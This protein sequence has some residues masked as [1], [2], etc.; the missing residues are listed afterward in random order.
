MTYIQVNNLNFT[1]DNATYKVFDN[2]SFAF[3]TNYKL[4]LIGRNGKGKTTFLKLLNNELDD[5]GAIINKPIT[6]YFP[7]NIIDET[8]DV[9]SLIYTLEPDVEYWKFLK[10]FHLLELEDNLLER[11]Y[12]TLSGGEKTKVQL[13]LLFSFDTHYLLIDE[14]T[15]H[16][17]L[18]GRYK[19]AEYLKKKDG[20]LL[21]SH[22]RSFLDETIDHVLSFDKNKIEL[23]SGNFSSWFKDRENIENLEKMRNTKL[24]KDI[25]KLESSVRKNVNWS[26]AVEKSKI[27]AGDKGYVGHMAAKAMKRAKN[28]ER[29][30]QNAIEERK[31]LLKNVEVMDDLKIHP[32]IYFKDTLVNFRDFS[33]RYD[34]ILFKPIRLTINQ[35]D[36][37]FIN[38]DN[39]SGKS[40]IIKAVIDNNVPYIGELLIGSRLKISYIPQDSSF[41]KGRLDDY[42]EKA[43]VNGDLMRSI[44]RK[45]DFKRELFREDMCNFSL[46]QKKK[47]LI[48]K[49]LSEEAHLYIWDEPLNYIDVFSR[50]MIEKLISNYNVTI[51]IIEHDKA[52]KDSIASKTIDLI[53]C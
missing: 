9:S 17:D 36:K 37:V 27:G 23:V 41:L 30:Q 38:G 22:D 4:G 53:E 42:I 44:L 3:D 51:L 18:K 10:E 43:N 50:I 16:L 2:V 25:S 11:A 49:S 8:L 45:L 35:N 7:Y 15:N 20:F 13:A 34:D 12:N 48:A 26:N 19:L 14:P 39:G 33:I 46:G 5:G 52:F 21:V 29:R 40:S 47:V 24:K 31:T 32:L 1:Y 6:S 28:I